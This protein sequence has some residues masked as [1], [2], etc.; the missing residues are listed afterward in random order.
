MSHQG[1]EICPID[2]TEDDS[3]SPKRKKQKTSGRTSMDYSEENNFDPIYQRLVEIETRI[4][5]LV[6][7]G[8]NDNSESDRF[9]DREAAGSSLLSRFENL[10]RRLG[11]LESSLES[12]A[13]VFTNPDL[14]G[15][16]CEN[17]ELP[18]RISEK[19]KKPQNPAHGVNISIAP[20]E[21][22]HSKA[23]ECHPASLITRAPKQVENQYPRERD[24]NSDPFPPENLAEEE[25][26][27]A[28][29]SDQ[30][31]VEDMNLEDLKPFIAFPGVNTVKEEVN[32]LRDDQGRV[33]M[34]LNCN[35]KRIYQNSSSIAAVAGMYLTDELHNEYGFVAEGSIKDMKIEAEIRAALF[36]IEI[37]KNI[38]SGSLNYVCVM[39]ISSCPTLVNAIK[40]D[41]IY[42][43]FY[44]CSCRV[45][46]CEHSESRWDTNDPLGKSQKSLLPDLMVAMKE[47][48][49]HW[50][51]LE[52]VSDEE[53][54]IVGD[55]KNLVDEWLTQYIR[56]QRKKVRKQSCDVPLNHQV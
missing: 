16:A 50:C 32:L 36:G 34:F 5:K 30:V 7:P 12:L 56:M 44:S 10:E 18:S 27:A 14:Q 28:H 35:A 17:S 24:R 38:F 8:N 52:N 11:S 47:L 49:V 51:K 20:A 9:V 1:S 37:V 2:L 42:P 55:Y 53:K 43:R 25:T 54:K 3:P 29:F 19:P 46:D 31:E 21:L 6:G 4:S 45:R 26:E 40:A 15:T 22:E 23:Y 13:Q 39:I 48:R 41:K 33:L